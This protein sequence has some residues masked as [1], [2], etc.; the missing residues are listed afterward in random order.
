MKRL[1]FVPILL[2]L[3]ACSVGTPGA[4]T[5]PASQVPDSQAAL[6]EGVTALSLDAELDYCGGDATNRAAVL[7]IE[8]GPQYWEVIPGQLESP[9]L[10][11]VKEPLDVVVYP[12]GWPA[13]TS[14]AVG[15]PRQTRRP[16]TWDVCV[17]VESGANVLAGTPFLV[18]TNVDPAGARIGP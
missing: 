6:P 12:Q 16:G 2:F 4:V 8:D 7:R 9:E 3:G 15:A 11:A 17:E 14:G 10:M 18:Y 13:R 5:S 1:L